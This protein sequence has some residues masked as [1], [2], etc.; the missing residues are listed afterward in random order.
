MILGIEAILLGSTDA[1]KLAQFYKDKV[2]LKISMEMEIGEDDEKA[3][4]VR[5]ENDVAFSI[6]DHSK[7]K[8]KSK[9]PNRI[10]FNLEVDNI[11][12][13]VKRLK[14]NGVKLVQDIYHVQDYGFV[15][16]FVDLDGNYF[17]LVK[18]KE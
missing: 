11:E 10:M 1:K 2:G 8:G 13:E 5:F 7:V 17:Q 15:S 6:F 16:T 18:T 14:K 12:K 9:D 4:V 3:F